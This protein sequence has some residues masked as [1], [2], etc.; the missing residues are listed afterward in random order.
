MMQRRPRLMY[1]THSGGFP[2]N[3]S[4]P[5]ANKYTPPSAKPTTPG[6]TRKAPIAQTG[7]GIFMSGYLTRRPLFFESLVLANHLGVVLALESDAA[8]IGMELLPL[9]FRLEFNAA[10]SPLT[11][12]LFHCHVC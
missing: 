7:L 9:T 4:A 3:E 10:F 6:G 11:E 2:I 8:L 1:W 12:F 5:A